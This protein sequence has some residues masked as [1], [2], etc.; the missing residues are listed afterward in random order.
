[1]RIA[2]T[3]SKGGIEDIIQPQFGRAATFTIVDYDG[4]VKNVEIVE[5][6]AASQVKWCGNSSVANAC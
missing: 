5:N 3:T 1:M 4:E 6:R 2:A